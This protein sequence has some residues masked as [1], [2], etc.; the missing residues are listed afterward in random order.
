MNFLTL[1]S[2]NLYF[3]SNLNFVLI[4]S[5]VWSTVGTSV[6]KS[7]LATISR[8]LNEVALVSPYTVTL[9][10]S[11]TAHNNQHIAKQSCVRRLE[12]CLLL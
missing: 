5:S 8:K 9:V 6:E 2:L 3:I 11:T 7:G 10:D 4:S 12:V 1:L